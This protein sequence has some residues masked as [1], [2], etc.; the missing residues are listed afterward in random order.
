MTMRIRFAAAVLATVGLMFLPV[1]PKA[2]SSDA[3]LLKQAVEF[4][5]AKGDVKGAIEIYK[6]LAQSPDKKIAALASEALR[7]LTN[8]AQAPAAPG[9]DKTFPERPAPAD[10]DHFRV[11]AFTSDGQRLF[12]GKVAG[13]G[14][15]PEL[16]LVERDLTTGTERTLVRTG[17]KRVGEVRLSPDGR[18]VA[19]RARTHFFDYTIPGSPTI[20]VGTE[21]LI[22]VSVDPKGPEAVILSW[23]N[24]QRGAPRI[25]GLTGPQLAWSAD[26]RLLAHLGPTPRSG[27]FELRIFNTI[28]R[29]SQSLGLETDGA[30]NFQWS[31]DGSQLAF[32]VMDTLKGVNDL[33]IVDMTGQTPAKDRIIPVPKLKDA[34]RLAGWTRRNDLVIWHSGS[35]AKATGSNIGVKDE[36]V[37]SLLSLPTGNFVEVCRGAGDLY[38]RDEY[39]WDGTV[40]RCLGVTPDGRYAVG[41]SSGTQRIVLR[42]T[43][44]NSDRP[45]TAASGTEIL[46]SISPDGRVIVFASNRSSEWGWYAALV[47][48][49]P[50]AAPALLTRMSG[51]VSRR[52]AQWAGDSVL[53]RWE[54]R[55]DEI[56]RV[57][58]DAMTGKSLAPLE[59]LTE[60]SI[61]ST[62]PAV[63]PDGKR[64]AF[65]VPGPTG[66]SLSMMDASGSTERIISTEPAPPD[67][68]GQRSLGPFWRSPEDVLFGAMGRAQVVHD[69]GS[70]SEPID[71]PEPLKARSLG[72]TG[73]I[74][75]TDEFVYVTKEPSGS[76]SLADSWTFRAH[77][78][79]GSGMRVLTSIASPGSLLH[80]WVVSFD[81]TRIAYSLG[82]GIAPPIELGLIDV[83][84]GAR[85]VLIPRGTAFAIAF[86]PNGRFLLHHTGSQPRVM[87]LA[88]GVAWPL[89]ETVHQPE[90]G[91]AL[92]RS[93]N[94]WAG[95]TGA[96]W[97]PDGTF[98]VIGLPAYQAQHMQ[99][100]NV[101]A[102]S[103][104]KLRQKSPR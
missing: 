58:I 21:D 13:S 104:E 57:S 36:L 74:A 46:P 54:N 15:R 93:L 95:G 64:I 75:S 48:A 69:A 2:Q 17:D 39:L 86:S 50:D 55:L 65:L 68:F 60:E 53:L 100:L 98:I 47:D 56:Y 16:S 29:S 85:R 88:T 26:G 79:T 7:R 84:T 1:S 34:R 3:V 24:L 22:V 72:T 42:D 45:L 90:T 14:L 92:L 8:S 20:E 37:V 30:P 73:F 18:W 103:L 31:P 52:D 63:S 61:H 81:G 25:I 4:E 71:L 41:W 91:T 12:A 89:V 11:G 19:A 97:S 33:H 49:Q 67:A 62:A 27:Q 28:T 32:Q 76:S 101:T 83:A 59:R 38:G 87:D 70:R 10:L 35:A 80:G 66:V 43:Q 94:G 5:K 23:G 78:T 44:T 77:A 9:V 96:S 99:W 6:R 82:T 51:P 40:N 102:A